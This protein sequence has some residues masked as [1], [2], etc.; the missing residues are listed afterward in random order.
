MFRETEH[1]NKLNIKKHPHG[2]VLEK[3]TGHQVK[4]PDTKRKENTG[5]RGEGNLKTRKRK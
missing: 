2:Y 1:K 4:C 5:V 3:N